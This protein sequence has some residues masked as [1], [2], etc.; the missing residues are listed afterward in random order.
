[1]SPVLWRT[2]VNYHCSL[3]RGFRC[4]RP[5]P[6]KLN[7]GQLLFFVFWIER[8]VAAPPRHVAAKRLPLT[9]IV[10]PVPPKLCRLSPL[11][12]VVCIKLLTQAAKLGY[13][14]IRPLGPVQDAEA[15]EP[16]T[17][18]IVRMSGRPIP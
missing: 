18:R 3:A 14:W 12:A 13:L 9:W 16:L 2:V 15:A 1:M 7:Q 10:S 17:E 5:S 11:S 6:H 4:L 8:P